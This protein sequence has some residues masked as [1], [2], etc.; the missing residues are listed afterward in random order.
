MKN[1][2]ILRAQQVQMNMRKVCL[3]LKPIVAF[4]YCFA[5]LAVI[6]FEIGFVWKLQCIINKTTGLHARDFFTCHPDHATK[7]SLA[8]EQ[9]NLAQMF[10]IN[11]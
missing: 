4:K 5:Q 1:T 8:Q 7:P 6:S 2:K 11:M 3:D 10:I 9:S